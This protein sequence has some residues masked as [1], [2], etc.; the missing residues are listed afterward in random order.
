MASTVDF[1]GVDLGASGGRVMLGR[2]DGERFTLRELHRFPNGPV[3]VHER[4]FWDHLRLWSE[5]KTGLE[6]Y[7]AEFGRSPESIGIDTWGVDYAL[8]D[9]AGNLLGNPYHYRDQATDG[10]L[11]AAFER[12]PREEIYRVTGVQFMQLNTL[13]QLLARR[14]AKDPQLEMAHRLLMTP[15]LFNYWLTG[16]QAVE[17]TIASTSQML[18]AHTRDWAIDLLRQLDIPTHILGEII[19]PGSELGELLPAV[20]D[21]VGFHRGV[22]VI[23]VG[24]HDTASAVA[25]VPELDETSAYISCGTWSLVGVESPRPIITERSLMLDVTNEGGVAHSIRVLKNITGLWLLQESRRQWRREGRDY[26]WDELVALARE[27][28]PLR[29]IIDPDAAEFARPGD[30]PAAIRAYCR[31]TNQPEPN[32]VGAV[33][34]C[35]LESMALKQRWVLELL[36]SLTGRRLEPIRMVGGGSQN[37]LLNQFTADA[38]NRPVAAGPVEAT[39]LGNIMMQAIATGHLNDVATGREA[40]AASFPRTFYEPHPSPAWDEAYEKLLS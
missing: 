40:I 31:R 36:E 7:T 25:A 28:P 19:P 12:A 11:E 18:N 16:R 29:S 27:A 21:E 4:L 15:D 2:W 9:K 17:Y 8:L 24:E 22:R 20:A 39:A 32:S 10:M 23:A 14:L 3:N 33:T 1:L 13:Y 5:I 37:Q 6:R 30:M 34:R 35:I 38:C 26:S